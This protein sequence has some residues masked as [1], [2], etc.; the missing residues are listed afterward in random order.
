M[1]F[2]VTVYA[3][4]STDKFYFQIFLSV[5]PVPAVVNVTW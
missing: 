3:D 5:D 2:L 1:S 4:L